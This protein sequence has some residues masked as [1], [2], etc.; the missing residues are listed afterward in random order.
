M[1]QQQIDLK[2]EEIRAEII[3]E[4]PNSCRSCSGRG[5]RV[6]P[7][8]EGCYETILCKECVLK[9]LD[10]L[11]MTKELIPFDYEGR[12]GSE[13]IEECLADGYDPR[14]VSQMDEEWEIHQYYKDCKSPTNGENINHGSWGR[15]EKIQS[16]FELKHD[17]KNLEEKYNRLL[18][19]G[20]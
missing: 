9:G 3:S 7:S 14:D 19:Q 6:I 16:L 5:G 11:D 1:N 10:P 8:W 15:S 4:Y 17:L 18:E 2:I 20:E 13:Y 12:Y